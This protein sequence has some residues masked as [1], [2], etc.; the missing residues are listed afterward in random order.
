M[1]WHGLLEKHMITKNKYISFWESCNFKKI[2][3]IKKRRLSLF[4][5]IK[6]YYFYYLF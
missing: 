6:K 5:K 2:L 1:D 3:N 4:L